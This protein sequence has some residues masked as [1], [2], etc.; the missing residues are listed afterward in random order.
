MCVLSKMQTTLF[1]V[2]VK[3]IGERQSSAESCL[4][5]E[6]SDVIEDNAA[7]THSSSK[8]SEA[9]VMCLG[10][11]CKPE[12]TEPNQPRSHSQLRLLIL[13]RDQ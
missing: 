10:A 9:S 2:G 12:R 7:D 4:G 8:I 1:D 11:C 13:K 5:L 3:S 6:S